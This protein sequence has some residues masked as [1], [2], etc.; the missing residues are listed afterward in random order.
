[1]EK[2]RGFACGRLWRRLRRALG[3]GLAGWGIVLLSAPGGLARPASVSDVVATFSIVA[4]D[5]STGA[6]GCAV[7]SRYFAVGAVVP[8]AEPDVGV[9][10]TQANV[11]VGYGPGGMALLRQGL[12]AERVLERLLAEDTFPGKDGRQVAIIDARGNVAV[13]TGPAAQDFAGHKKGEHYSVQGNIL[14]GPAVIEAMAAAFEKASGSLAE[15]LLASLEAGQEAGGDRRGQQS[16]ALLVVQKGVGRNINND[17]AVRLHVDDHEKPI[18]E[19][20]RLLHIQLALSALQTSRR[21]RSEQKHREALAEAERAVELWPDASD[22]R[23]NLGLLAY[24]AGDKEALSEL[25]EAMKRN[26]LFRGQLESMLKRPEFE[27]LAKDGDFMRTLF[28]R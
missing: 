10:A 7:E 21:L 18:G 14:A 13:Y 11:N 1:M 19:L 22:T 12:T 5:P 8:W 20:R 9:I 2:R 23:M 3:A 26:P 15:R 16:A 24:A 4:R 25:Q 27:A 17:V 28:P 6:L